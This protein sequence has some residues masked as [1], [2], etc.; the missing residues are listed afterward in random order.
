MAIPNIE[1]IKITIVSTNA[2]LCL[3]ECFCALLRVLGM[4]DKIVWYCQVKDRPGKQ[5]WSKTE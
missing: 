3:Y 4:I 1:R 2:F 5:L